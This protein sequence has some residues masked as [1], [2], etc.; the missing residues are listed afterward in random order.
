MF[1]FR[2][3]EIVDGYDLHIGR[4]QLPA[5]A[6]DETPNSAESL[7]A[8]SNHYWESEMTALAD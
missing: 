4:V 6:E 1:F 2:S 7:D 3:K 5:R 8:N